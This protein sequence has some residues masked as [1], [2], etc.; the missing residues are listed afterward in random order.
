MQEVEAKGLGVRW[1]RGAGL[2][3]GAKCPDDS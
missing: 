1:E 2:G 3:E